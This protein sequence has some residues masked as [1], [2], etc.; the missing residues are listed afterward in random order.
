MCS[1]DLWRSAFTGTL[2]QEMDNVWGTHPVLA[3]GQ[4]RTRLRLK[5]VSAVLTGEVRDS[6]H[7]LWPTEMFWRPFAGVFFDMTQSGLPLAVANHFHSHPFCLVL[8][9]VP[10]LSLGGDYQKDV[11]CAMRAF[12]CWESSN[13]RKR[14]KECRVQSDSPA[15]LIQEHWQFPCLQWGNALC[16]LSFHPVRFSTD[17]NTGLHSPIYFSK[18]VPDILQCLHSS[19]K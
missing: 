6:I 10:A 15:L 11:L 18:S 2:A 14:R 19:C 8:C 12:W 5:R 3:S 1:L 16:F 13:Q 7:L 4:S 9:P 17:S